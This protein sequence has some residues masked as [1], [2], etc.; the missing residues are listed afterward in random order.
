MSSVAV[1]DSPIVAYLSQSPPHPFSSAF[2]HPHI[3]PVSQPHLTST[4]TMPILLSQPP[5]PAL[6][7]SPHSP[8]HPPLLPPPFLC[9]CLW[10]ET[11][12]LVPAMPVTEPVPVLHT[13]VALS[14][15]LCTMTACSHAL[16]G[17]IPPP[18]TQLLHSS[19]TSPPSTIPKHTA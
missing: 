3:L 17:M 14:L 4:N 10:L 18:H 7:H 1:V 16:S 5:H 2:V 11:S 8:V 12:T 6:P 13:L 9:P 15:F 19:G